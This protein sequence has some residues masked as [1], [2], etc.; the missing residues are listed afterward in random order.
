M[1]ALPSIDLVSPLPPVRSG[2]SD[3]AADLL[4]ELGRRADLR[5]VLL[6]G[7]PVRESLLAAWPTVDAESFA[8]QAGATLPGDGRVPLYQMGNNHHHQ[9]VWRLA[10]ARPGV[11]VLHDLVLHHFLL[12]RTAARDRLEEYD[13]ELEACHGWIGRAASRPL[14]WP[15]GVGT[16]AQF[17][18]AAHRTLLGRQRGI[19]VHSAW[20]A[21]T[22]R[23]EIPGLRVRHIQMGM[24]LPDAAD[25]E[26]GRLFRRRHG[27]PESV[28]VIG[29]F[30]FQTPIKRTDA[31]IRTLARPGL[32]KVHLMVAGEAA[33][34]LDLVGLAREAGVAERV[35]VLGFLP[36][37]EF[38]AGIAAADLALNLRYPTAGE[39]SASLLRIL[40][41]GRP[42]IVTDHAQMADLPPEIVVAIAPGEG[43]EEALA[44]RL[45]ALLADEASLC[46]MGQAAR[47][48]VA[49]HHRLEVAAQEVVS[50]C[51]DWA[52]AEPLGPA[53]VPVPIPTSLAWTAFEGEIEVDG[54]DDPW[55]PGERRRLRVA[56]RNRSRARW[57]AGERL[58]GGLA[59]QP[60]LW[61]NG[62][63]RWAERPWVGL[64][65]DLE[66]GREHVFELVLRRPLDD[67]VRLELVPHVLG[68]T[69][70]SE[71]GGPNWSKRL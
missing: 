21:E 38:E 51:R 54:A 64:P 30:G 61:V 16:A 56:L 23:D 49:E 62:R 40:A 18:L 67:D 57:L 35:H 10:M 26:A 3:Y 4:P 48:Y 5:L 15:G 60:K 25:A 41:V 2:I 12:E 17:S 50:A 22:L 7:Q 20:A 52:T 27:V 24:P 71:L 6:P 59:L 44:E 39:T 63:D 19:L 1:G 11:L 53:R 46:R 68:H 14:H 8:R 9:D 34:N 43:E 70:L 42:A 37:E 29:S 58:D 31:V 66:P 32:E 13:A 36:F 55:P 33:P 45:V 28:P 69:R 65:R 47:R